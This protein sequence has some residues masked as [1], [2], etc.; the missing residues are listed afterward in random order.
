MQGIQLTHDA[1]N[2]ATVPVQVLNIS[3]NGIIR[4]VKQKTL[5]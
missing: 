4:R 5:I 3:F 1:D 2:T